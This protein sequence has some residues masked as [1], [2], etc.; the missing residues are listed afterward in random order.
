[1]KTKIKPDKK[2]R[3]IEFRRLF[4]TIPA[5]SNAARI[6]WAADKLMIAENTVRIYLMKTPPRVPTRLSLRVLAD[7]VLK[8][9]S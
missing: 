4:D 5:E 8:A 3:Q 9:K 7:E 2:A 6:R 1:M